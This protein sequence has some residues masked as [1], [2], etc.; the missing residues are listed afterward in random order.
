M[1]HMH[2]SNIWCWTQAELLCSIANA[3]GVNGSDGHHARSQEKGEGTI[4]E[5]SRTIIPTF[6]A[7]IAA[8]LHALL[9]KSENWDWTDICQNAFDALKDAVI[10]NALLHRPDFSQPFVIQVNCSTQG[11][12]AVLSQVID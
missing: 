10:N 3:G 12:G 11:L 1:A 4:Y 9:S 5:N 2:A 7:K 6:Y 8:P